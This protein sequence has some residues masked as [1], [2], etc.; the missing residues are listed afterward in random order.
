MYHCDKRKRKNSTLSFH[1]EDNGK[2]KKK[3]GL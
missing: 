1:K 2:I 3:L